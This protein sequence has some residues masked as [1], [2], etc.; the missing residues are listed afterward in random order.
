[1]SIMSLDSLLTDIFTVEATK[2]TQIN[3]FVFRLK[4]Y[5][6]KDLDSTF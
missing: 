3:I 6:T 5:F 1:M 4:K 2:S